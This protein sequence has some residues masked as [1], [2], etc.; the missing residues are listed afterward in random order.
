MRFKGVVAPLGGQGG[1]PRG[2]GLRGGFRGSFCLVRSLKSLFVFTACTVQKYNGKPTLGFEGKAH[3][4]GD[5]LPNS[6]ARF[7]P[8]RIFETR[9]KRR[10]SPKS[11]VCF[12]NLLISKRL[13][14]RV[15]HSCLPTRTGREKAGFLC[16]TH[17]LW[18]EIPSLQGSLRGMIKSCKSLSYKG[19]FTKE[20][21][22]SAL[23]D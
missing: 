17:P 10:F 4:C 14:V 5:D 19:Q 18:R 22:D 1:W 2:D 11:V 16:E 23:I 6:P 12:R 3:L 13:S 20:N 21:W 8:G 9:R 7:C 15:G